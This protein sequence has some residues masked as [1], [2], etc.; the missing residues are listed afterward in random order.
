MSDQL[1]HTATCGVKLQG[2]S[3][4]DDLVEAIERY[5]VRQEEKTCQ[6]PANISTQVPTDV[7]AGSRGTSGESVGATS[8]ESGCWRKSFKWFRKQRKRLQTQYV[9]FKETTSG[10]VVLWIIR[11]IFRWIAYQLLQKA[12]TYFF[13]LL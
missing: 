6:E 10:K 7:E 12:G 11:Q 1:T 13:D 8:L 4:L 3:S 9:K 5:S 2:A